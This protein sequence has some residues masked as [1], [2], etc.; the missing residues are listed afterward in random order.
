MQTETRSP[1]DEFFVFMQIGDSKALV[2]RFTAKNA[3]DA[4]TVRAVYEF[5]KA[6]E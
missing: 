6:V 4:P 3:L 1:E 2:Y 5:K